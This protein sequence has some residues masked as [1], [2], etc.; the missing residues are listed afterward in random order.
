MAGGLSKMVEAGCT[1]IGGHSVRDPEIKFG[2]SVTGSVH[3]DN[4][5]KNS[6]ARAGDVLILT[7]PLG[8]GVISTAIKRN[9][10]QPGWIDAAEASM[11]TLNKTAVEVIHQGGFIVHA[12][13]DV[14]GFGLIGHAREMALASGVSLRIDSAN[15]DLV[16]GDTAQPFFD[17]LARFVYTPPGMNL[18]ASDP[19]F[20]ERYRG[21]DGAVYEN[22]AGLP[23]Y[24]FVK[25]Y[26]VE[27]EFE[28]ALWF[29][30]FIAD[31]H[32]EAIVDHVPIQVEDTRPRLSSIGSELHIIRY[33][34]NETEL[35]VTGDGWNLLVSSD[36]RWRGWR[37]Y[38]NDHRIP[39]VTVNGTFLGCFV[40]R[41]RRGQLRF[42]YMPDELV[43]SARVSLAA[44]IVF[45]SAQLA[46]SLRRRLPDGYEP[47]K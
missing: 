2:Y 40:P 41:G 11:T 36:N 34:E 5:W 23:R 10:A 25:H 38:W 21:N 33:A 4:V 15:P 42:R 44:L 22:M 35:D 26:R 43:R 18:A 17:Y 45:V 27:P 14:T 24:F 19:E 28:R 12:A 6:T 29:S 30:R 7:K 46:L 20:I 37:A 47:E 9:E 3:P 39:V 16:I 8:T 1:V 13:T 32:R 31:F